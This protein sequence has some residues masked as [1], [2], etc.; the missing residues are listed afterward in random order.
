MNPSYSLNK[1]LLVELLIVVK[2]KEHRT[3]FVYICRMKTSLMLL[4]ISAIMKMVLSQICF[5][6]VI[7][8]LV[9]STGTI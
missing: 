9:S 8:I 2:Y 1:Y 3:I 7:Y 4:H 5:S 6:Y